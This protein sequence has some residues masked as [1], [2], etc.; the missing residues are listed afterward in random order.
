MLRQTGFRPV[1]I[2]VG[3][4]T[5]YQVPNWNTQ[6]TTSGGWLGGGWN[7][8]ELPDYTQAL[9]Q[10]RSLAMSRMEIEARQF[11]ASGVIGAKIEVKAEPREVEVGNNQH[12]TDM[13]YHFT[14]LG[15][16]IAPYTGRWPVF[17]VLNTV[18][19]K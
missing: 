12:R 17:Q 1:G 13:L 5:Y 11:E 16:A 10:A 19:L 7:N 3:N 8:Q 9:Y 14:A 18:S 15:T 4:C 2:V 6:V